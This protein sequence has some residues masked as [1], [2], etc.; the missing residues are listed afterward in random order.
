MIL[1]QIASPMTR[2]HW[3]IWGCMAA[4]LLYCM[5]FMNHIFAITSISEKS[6]MLLVIF[7]L[8]TEPAFRYLS[9][10]TRKLSEWY[11]RRKN[12]V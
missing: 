9:I 4:G 2:Y 12:A 6:F 1:Y 8:L 3:L 11:T 10:L 7:A 5:I